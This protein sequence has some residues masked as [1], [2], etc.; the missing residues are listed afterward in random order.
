M[1][2]AIRISSIDR[3]S[4]MNFFGEKRVSRNMLAPS[5]LTT[6]VR[7][8]FALFVVSVPAFYYFRHDGLGSGRAYMPAFPSP[9]TASLG[10]EQMS[11]KEAFIEK[12]LGTEID[13]PFDAK[14]L[15]DLCARTVWQEG[16]VMSCEATRGGGMGNI[17]NVFVDCVRFVIE[18]GGTYLDIWIRK[19][20]G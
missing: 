4:Q 1:G 10:G 6:V 12:I 13:G 5:N 14:P 16:L 9:T 2:I 8:A 17:R 19:E 7:L 15:Q 11:E 3:A 20:K 18:A